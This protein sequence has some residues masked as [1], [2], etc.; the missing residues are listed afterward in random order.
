M[1]DVLFSR[2]VSDCQ[3]FCDDA[4]AFQCRSFS[5]KNDRCYLSGDDSGTL[6]GIPKP[7]DPGSV[8]KEKICSKSTCEGGIF[9][10]EK[11]TG[12]FLRTAKEEPLFPDTSTPGI[13][14]KCSELC[15]GLDSDCPSFSLDYSGQRCFKLDRNTQ[16]RGDSLAPRDGTNYFEKICLKGFDVR[17]RCQNKVWAFERVPGK[18]LDVDPD[19]IYENISLRRGCEEL[20]L[21]EREFICRSAN[22]DSITLKCTLSRYDRRMLGTE[23]KN[24]SKYS[25]YL[26]NNC[27]EPNQITCPYMKIENAYPRYLDEVVRNIKDEVA[28]E[29]QCSFNEK[30]IC[31][32]FAFYSSASQCFISGDDI[33][34]ASEGALQTRPGTDYFQRKCKEGLS[35]RDN[36]IDSFPS[37]SEE[38][39]TTRFDMDFDRNRRPTSATGAMNKR[40]GKSEERSCSFG[41]LT[42]EKTTGYELIRGNPTR[43]YSE[44]DGGIIE[45]CASRCDEDAD[46]KGFNMDYNRNECQ[47]LTANSLNNLFNLRTSSGV[48]YFE[49]TCLRGSGCGLLWTYERFVNKELK[50]DPKK[51]QRDVSKNECEDLC[52]S[53]SSFV[54]KSANYDHVR[55]D[56]FLL[57]VDRFE[58]DQSLQSRQ[59]VDYLENQCEAIKRRGCDYGPQTKDR[60]LIYTDKVVKVFS[61]ASCREACSSERSFYC[62]SYTFLSESRPGRPQC[63]LSGDNGASSGGDNAFQLSN[64]AL[65]SELDCSEGFTRPLMNENRRPIEV[66]SNPDN[67]FVTSGGAFGSTTSNSKSNPNPE[68][69]RSAGLST[70][71][72]KVMDFTYDRGPEEEFSTSVDIGIIVQCLRECQ[73]RGR[74]CLAATLRNERGGR[75]SCYGLGN[76][77]TVDGTEPVAATGVTYFEKICVNRNCRKSWAFTKIPQYEF[78]G[79]PNKEVQDVESISDCRNLCLDISS[80]ACRSMTYNRNTR[81]CRMTEETRRSSPSEFRPAERGVDYYENE[82]SK[83]P[84]NCEY[85]DN[86]GMYLPFTDTYISR[87]S[88]IEEC[89]SQCS[90][91]DNYNCRSFNFNSFRKEC[92]LSSDD[93]VSLPSGLH[94]DRDFTFSERGGCNNGTKNHVKKDVKVECTPSDMLV[95]L[96]FGAEF[97]GRIYAT[98]NPQACFELGTGQS[99]MIL[100]IPISSQCGTVQQNPGRYVN[101]VVIQENPVIMQDTDKTVRVECAFTAEDQTVSFRPTAGVGG[102]LESGGGISV[103]VPFQPTGTNI[104]TNTAPTPGVRMRVIRR[105]GETASMVG[106]GENLQLRIEIDRDSAFGLFARKLEAKTD[107]GE[108]MNLIDEDGCPINEIIFPALELEGGTRALYANFKAFRFP[109]TPIVN[110]IATVQFCQDLCKPMPCSGGS[111]SFGKRRKRSTQDENNK[112][113]RSFFP[114]TDEAEGHSVQPRTSNSFA[115]DSS[116]VQESKKRKT[117]EDLLPEH[118]DLGLRL[119]VGENVLHKPFLPSRHGGGVF[120]EF[121]GES[122]RDS[123]SQYY[124][125]SSSSVS[126]VNTEEAEYLCSSQSTVIVAI[127]VILVFNVLLTAGFILFYRRKRKEW[128]KGSNN[129]GPALPPRPSGSVI[130]KNGRASSGSSGF[131]LTTRQQQRMNS[132]MSSLPRN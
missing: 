60:Y 128:I 58:I 3:R 93:S 59:G 23:Y 76:S 90:I 86:T 77:A 74:L 110:F 111:E 129:A 30:I 32:S 79:S 36:Q 124:P 14:E 41:R 15:T 54:C 66:G 50:V 132:S 67:T 13:T 108:L 43:L 72:E 75:Q 9:T 34:S 17:N 7:V 130:F 123:N 113:E 121:P 42:Y 19:Q 68:N 119:T 88:D 51:I 55:R 37:G 62:R 31:R 11:T 80:F 64:G 6:P 126:E 106:L 27:I 82:C 83:I 4:R 85:V 73:S 122:Q 70:S 103:T 81:M 101:H 92:F 107:N 10:Y 22:Y 25:N 48:S 96:A 105:N 118:I 63:L 52:L 24:T 84:S 120:P 12:H 94:Q 102:R 116:N 61:D 89:R 87:V 65:F 117:K 45:Q 56:C 33:I 44:R 16:I 26:E 18:M 35:H 40:K 95:N 69:C 1:D 2:T 100:K 98:G 20:C 29:V 99:E 109:S 115:N 114:I 47:S 91:Q 8:Y 127:F 46:C 78:I 28:C 57:N 125:S 131:A 104:V 97:N 49:T 39:Q 53:E 21:R 71:F 5:Q 38:I 112:E